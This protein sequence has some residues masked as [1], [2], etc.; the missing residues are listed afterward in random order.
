M[1]WGL[2]LQFVLGL[3]VIR[4]E[5]GFIAFQWLG[6]QI[7]VCEWCPAAQAILGCQGMEEKPLRW[8]KVGS[9]AAER[10]WDQDGRCVLGPR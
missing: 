2:G 3:L 4:T 5:P 9:E 7:Q 8:G 1:S 10:N 6:D